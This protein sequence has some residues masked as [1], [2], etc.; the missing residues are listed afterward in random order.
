MEDIVKEIETFARE[1]APK[2][3]NKKAPLTATQRLADYIQNKDF[4]SDAW[5]NAQ[6]YLRSKYAN[7]P[8]NLKELDAFVSSTIVVNG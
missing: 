7:N 3:E 5:S 4:Y 8:E 2:R 1:K 6:D